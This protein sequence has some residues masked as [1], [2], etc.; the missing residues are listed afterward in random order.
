M[1]FKRSKQRRAVVK[2]TFRRLSKRSDNGLK[3]H[4]PEN[5]H[6][7]RVLLYLS[8]LII[9]ENMSDQYDASY[10]SPDSSLYEKLRHME[11]KLLYL[12]TFEASWQII[13][14]NVPGEWMRKTTEVEQCFDIPD[15]ALIN[16]KSECYRC[17]DLKE[18]LRRGLELDVKKTPHTTSIPPS[19]EPPMAHSLNVL[20]SVGPLVR[21]PDS[22]Q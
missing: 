5:L 14:N 19:P 2:N 9:S 11:G 3:V 17:N 16:S 4:V 12:F 13:V 20:S 18:E 7:H 22:G 1:W 8:M 10:L 15:V 6:L 21:H